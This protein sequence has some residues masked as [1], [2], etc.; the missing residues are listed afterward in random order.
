[1]STFKRFILYLFALYLILAENAIRFALVNGKDSAHEFSLVGTPSSISA[2][3]LS[4][5]SPVLIPK[6][7]E[8]DQAG[9]LLLR[10]KGAIARSPRDEALV[11]AAIAAL[12]LLPFLWGWALYLVHNNLNDFIIKVEYGWAPG[13]F[14]SALVIYFLGIIMTE[15]KEAK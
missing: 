10:G 5:I 4:L 14:L 6:P 11:G 13:A 7:V 15:A 9:Q 1:M 2:A 8:L 3:G 12:V